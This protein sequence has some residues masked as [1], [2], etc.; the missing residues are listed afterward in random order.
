M[1]HGS[2]SSN[3]TLEPFLREAAAELVEEDERGEAGGADRVALRH[4]LRRV[5]DGVERVG[6]PADG[7][8]Q[9]GHLGDPA[10][11]VGHRPVRVERDDEARHRE[12]RHDRDADAVQLPRRPM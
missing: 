5:A 8:G 1:T 10:R 4:R 2:L 6:D 12:L 3:E 11:V 7:L 9:I